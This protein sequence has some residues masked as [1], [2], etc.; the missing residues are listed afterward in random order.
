MSSVIVVA[1]DSLGSVNDNFTGAIT[2]ALASNPTG[3]GLSGTKTVRASNG[4]ATFGDL[5]VDRPGTYRLQAI[6]SGSS[7]TSASFTIT[8]ATAP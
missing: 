4:V 6:A 5:S 3:A 7:V 2:V 1:S 8:T